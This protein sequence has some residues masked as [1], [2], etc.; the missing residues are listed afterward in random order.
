MQ[1]QLRDPDKVGFIIVAGSTFTYDEPGPHEIDVESLPLDQRNQLLYN[2]RRQVLACSEPERLVELCEAVMPAAKSYSTPAEKPI[3]P[4]TAPQIDEVVDPIEEDLK[5]LKAMLQ[6]GVHKIKKQAR[7]MPVG[8]VRKLLELE[9]KDKNRKSLT[10]FLNEILA[11]HA[12][13]VL[14]S[15]GTEDAGQKFT[16][17]GVQQIGSKQ[18][19]D[20]VESEL[21]QVVLNPLEDVNK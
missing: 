7:D 10:S 5:E 2:C 18:V 15:V 19:T 6:L 8:R 20:V 13:N 14:D 1:F 17:V 21:E 12:E 16:P 4:N 3:T 11:K 9:G